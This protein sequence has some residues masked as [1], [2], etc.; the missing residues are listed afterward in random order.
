MTMMQTTVTVWR[1][2]HWRRD[3]RNIGGS[4]KSDGEPGTKIL[5]KWGVRKSNCR[6]T[7]SSREGGKRMSCNK[8]L[9][10]CLP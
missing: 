1:L 10:A 6:G 4:W 8:G 9:K 3:P 7:Q 5:D 2:E